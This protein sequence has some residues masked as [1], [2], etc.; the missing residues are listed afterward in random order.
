MLFYLKR[1]VALIPACSHLH[2]IIVLC[3]TSIL[4]AVIFGTSLTLFLGIT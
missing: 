1:P 2:R 3:V 4:F